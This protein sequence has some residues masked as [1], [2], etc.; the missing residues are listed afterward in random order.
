MRNLYRVNQSRS[1]ATDNPAA[2]GLPCCRWISLVSLLLLAGLSVAGTLE[3]QPVPAADNAAP[4]W[5]ANY[6]VPLTDNTNHGRAVVSASLL[7]NMRLS[8]P[9]NPV[10]VTLVGVGNH[11]PV[12]TSQ[13]QCSNLVV[14]DQLPPG[15]YRI[16]S[17]EGNIDLFTAPERFLFPLP[18]DGYQLILTGGSSGLYRARVPRELGAII[19][20]HAGATTFAGTVQTE[21]RA[22]HPWGIS[23]TWDHALSAQTALCLAFNQSYELSGDASTGDCD[24]N[25][26][27][28]VAQPPA[29]PS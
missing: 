23:I 16:R 25:R 3:T 1:L 2:R 13:L 8:I 9:I 14:F 15:E 26:Q 12:V 11:L 10:K 27:S 24:V 6:R 19:K 20:V 5:C 7:A 18:Q 22:R 4:E 28:T 29:E 21:P 17:I